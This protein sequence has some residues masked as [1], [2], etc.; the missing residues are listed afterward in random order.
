MKKF[1]SP[2]IK[3]IGGYKFTDPDD[4]F[5]YNLPYKTFEELENHVV[6][7]RA[8]NGY[9]RIEAFRAVWESYICE[10]NPSM[11]AKCCDVTEVVKRSFEQYFSGAK[12]FVRMLV[13]KSFVDQ[14]TA[15]RRAAQCVSCTQN[16]KNIGHSHG[17]F[18]SNL[19]IKKQVGDRKTRFDDKLFTCNICTCILKG[20][21]HYGNKEVGESLSDTEVGRLMREPRHV[22]TGKKIKCWQLE[23]ALAGNEE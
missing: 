15:D 5:S 3:P 8:Q 7:Y 14:M 22:K 1:I 20:K 10:N 19:F 12:A 17:Q 6:R 4:G 2:Q 11:F 13:K 16:V 18:Y 9:P 21:V 23:A